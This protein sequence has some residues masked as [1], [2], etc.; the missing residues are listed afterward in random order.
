M[1]KNI[2]FEQT[3]SEFEING[4]SDKIK[5][6]IALLDSLSLSDEVGSHKYQAKSYETLG[7]ILNSCIDDIENLKKGIE[8]MDTKMREDISN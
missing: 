2:D 4:I 8:Y 1:S 7:L 6:V 3:V 5:G